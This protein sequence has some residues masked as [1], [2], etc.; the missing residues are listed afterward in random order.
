MPINLATKCRFIRLSC[1]LRGILKDLEPCLLTKDLQ[2]SAKMILQIIVNQNVNVEIV[3]L[4]LT[5]PQFSQ[6]NRPAARR[7]TKGKRAK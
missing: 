3:A 4:D 7:E 6:K 5:L 2:T 1:Q